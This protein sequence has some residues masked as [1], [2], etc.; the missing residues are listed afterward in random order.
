V[1][2]RRFATFSEFY[3]FYLAEHASRA[4]RRLH[5]AGTLCV[6]A[7][8]AA[9]LLARDVRWLIA[10]PLGGYGLAWIGHFF[11]EHNRPATFHHPFY[12]LAGDF[13]MFGDV[14]RGRV[15]L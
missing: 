15:K 13:A 12:S 10:A 5:I 2:V 6:I 1:A 9:A 8:V 7:A 11:F 4:C 14:L 3:P